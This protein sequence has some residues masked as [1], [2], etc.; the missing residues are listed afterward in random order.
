MY[1]IPM[2]ATW[3]AGYTLG[4]GHKFSRRSKGDRRPRLSPSEAGRDEGDISSHGWGG[5]DDSGSGKQRRSGDE[6]GAGQGRSGLD[7]ADMFSAKK[8]GSG[9]GRLSSDL[10]RGLVSSKHAV[11]PFHLVTDLISCVVC[12]RV[13]VCVM[14][15]SGWRRGLGEQK[16]AWP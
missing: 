9:D 11:C 16:K 3:C 7:N 15:S 14:F 8:G 12:T 2:V 10:N 5:G 1:S 6:G 4:S 13:C